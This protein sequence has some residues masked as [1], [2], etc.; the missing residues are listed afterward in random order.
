MG[1]LGR[2]HAAQLGQFYPV[3]YGTEQE[4]LAQVSLAAADELND[5]GGDQSGFAIV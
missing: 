4:T 3:P 1:L 5:L 2:P